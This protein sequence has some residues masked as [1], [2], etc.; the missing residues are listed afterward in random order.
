MVTITLNEKNTG[1]DPLTDVHVTG[2]ST[3]A[4]T[5]CTWVPVGTFDGNLDVGESQDFS[6]TYTVGTVNVDWVADGQGI[7]SLGVAVPSGIHTPEHQEGM[8]PT[9]TV[10]PLGPI[11]GSA[12]PAVTPELVLV[13]IAILML[14]V[15][16]V[17]PVPARFRRRI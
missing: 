16:F 12:G 4:T 15:A 3:G 17:T 7:D 10:A 5:N 14:G 8:V 2:G 11:A 9:D 13:V 1:D 6:C